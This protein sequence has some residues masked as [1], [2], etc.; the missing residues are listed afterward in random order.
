MVLKNPTIYHIIWTVR[1]DS[2][3]TH[4]P[5]DWR[6]HWYQQLILQNTLIIKTTATFHSQW[7]NIKSFTS[8]TTV[9]GHC[10]YHTS[11]HKLLSISYGFSQLLRM[12]FAHWYIP[13]L[14]RE[15]IVFSFTQF[16]KEFV[17]LITLIRSDQLYNPKQTPD[18]CVIVNGN[19]PCKQY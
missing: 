18:N 6:L 1:Q 5:Q 14:T 10:G 11:Q 16:N 7:R 2:M 12:C 9:S 13:L 19:L 3:P 15:S 4:S 8:K 17:I